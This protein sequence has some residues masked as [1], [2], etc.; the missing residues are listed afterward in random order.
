MEATLLFFFFDFFKAALGTHGGSQARG[1]IGAT[2][3]SLHHGHKNM[4]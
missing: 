3:A 4:E 1:Q 2:A